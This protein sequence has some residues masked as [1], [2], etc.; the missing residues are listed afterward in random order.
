MLLRRHPWTVA[1]AR[2]LYSVTRPRFTMGVVG[3]LFNPQ[4]Q[5]L[6]VEHVF[7][8][9]LPWGL[10]G[11]WVERNERP[12]DGLLRELREE[13]QVKATLGALLAIDSLEHNHLDIAYLCSTT[14]PIGKLSY[15]LLGYQ[16]ADPNALPPTHDFHRLA[17]EQAQ[18]LFAL[19]L[20]T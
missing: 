7:H 4:G 5:V 18:A 1:I 2:S 13:L 8:P 19:E 14:D 10:P 17:I 11:G 16:W 3:V 6:L 12:G 20:R 15:E 9:Y